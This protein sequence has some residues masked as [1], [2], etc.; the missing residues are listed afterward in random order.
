MHYDT[1][2]IGNNCRKFREKTG[3]SQ[4]NVAAMIGKHQSDIS[5]FENGKSKGVHLDLFL[6]YLDAVGMTAL[7]AFVS[8]QIGTNQEMMETLIYNFDKLSLDDKH[9]VIRMIIG[10]NHNSDKQ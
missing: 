4:E 6:A 10:L 9:A 7:D 3:L 8:S 1:G 2:M 5:R